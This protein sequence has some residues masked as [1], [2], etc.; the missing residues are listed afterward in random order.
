MIR[1]EKKYLR[2][3]LLIKIIVVA[4]C[5]QNG[6]D[7]KNT[8]FQYADDKS[9]TFKVYGMCGDVICASQIGKKGEYLKPSAKTMKAV[10]MDFW[11]KGI[12]TG[13]IVIL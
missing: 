3:I 7:M 12:E 1:Y 8:T 11:N 6:K 4:L 5:Q 2:I 9:K 13:F 10:T